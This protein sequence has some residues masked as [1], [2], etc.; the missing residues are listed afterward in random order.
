MSRRLAM[1]AGLVVLAVSANAAS[2]G[3]SSSPLRLGDP[4]PS[5]DGGHWIQGTPIERPTPDVVTVV[6]FFATDNVGLFESITEHHQLTREFGESV[7]VVGVSIGSGEGG[8]PIGDLAEGIDELDYPLL[9]DT[10]DAILVRRWLVPAG[11]EELPVSFVFGK[12]GRLAWFGEPWRGM[13][14]VVASVGADRF[15]VA[16]FRRARLDT[17]ATADVLFEDLAPAVLAEDW[18]RVAKLAGELAVLDRQFRT[19]MTLL[20]YVALI[21]ARRPESAA[22]YGEDVMKRHHGD[23]AFLNEFAWTI[24]DPETELDSSDRDLVLATRAAERAAALTERRRDYVLDTLARCQFEL[25]EVDLAV[26]TQSEAV[27]VSVLRREELSEVL[28][29]YRAAAGEER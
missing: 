13:F 5:F 20:R 21:H 18:R 27:E 15:D 24:V 26:E 14:D 7:A 16:A 11:V 25:G 12:D 3:Q 17:E 9:E 23:P 19:S 2:E 10:G 1:I 8:I 22:R 4:A 28:D 6:S 29:A